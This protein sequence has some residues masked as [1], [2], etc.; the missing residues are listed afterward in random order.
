M[1]KSLVFGIRAAVATA[2]AVAA[3]SVG[4]APAN[5]IV[6]GGPATSTQAPWSAGVFGNG[7]FKCSGSLIASQYVLTA[8]HCLNNGGWEGLSVRVGDLRLGQG[9]YR[10][11]ISSFQRGSSPSDMTV[12]KLSSPIDGAATLTLSDSEPSIGH[13]Y[14]A[15][16]WGATSTTS[17]AA[18]PVLKQA[19]VGV[20]ATGTQDILGGRAF[21]VFRVS[22]MPRGGDSGGPLVSGGRAIGVIS[23]GDGSSG[24]AITEMN[25][26]VSWIRAVTG[27]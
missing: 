24:A 12:L 14:A 7:L 15:Y 9:T 16:G 6:G 17:T 13:V 23:S 4:T 21:F 5:A 2:T 1:R 26:N 20:Q 3:V 22:G 8:R 11:V 27:L 19:T 18:S 10:D 25:D